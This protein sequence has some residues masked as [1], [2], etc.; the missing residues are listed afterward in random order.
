MDAFVVVCS[1]NSNV[2]MV[3]SWMLRCPS[4]LEHERY[5]GLGMDA[6]V[7][8]CSRNTNVTMVWAWMLWWPSALG[9]PSS[10]WLRQRCFRNRTLQEDERYYCCIRDALVT[11]CSRNTNVIMVWA[12]TLWHSYA[13]GTRTL[14]WLCHGCSGD[15]LL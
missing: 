2:I 14:L 12:W 15:C 7:I 11:V 8:V 9:T 1:R 4:A 5:Y 13:L 6:F 10:L 3:S